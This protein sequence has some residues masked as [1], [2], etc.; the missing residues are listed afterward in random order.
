MSISSSSQSCNFDQV[1]WA[2]TAA[3]HALCLQ[4]LGS[5]TCLGC[6]FQA[7]PP[8]TFLAPPGACSSKGTLGGM[9]HIFLTGQPGC[10]KSTLIQ[11]VLQ[12]L[13]STLDVRTKVKGA[14]CP[15]ACWHQLCAAQHA[16]SACRNWDLICRVLYGGGP[17][18]QGTHR[19]RC[20]H[21]RRPEGGAF[22]GGGRP[23]GGP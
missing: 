7:L 10:G 20:G 21:G 9:P 12:G 16:K 3:I 1:W 15:A 18:G 11:R 19:L 2:Y 23:A 8:P 14:C 5:L 13:G 17:S 4:L 22:P 6:G